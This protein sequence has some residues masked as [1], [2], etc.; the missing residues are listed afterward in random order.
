MKI[1]IPCVL[2]IAL[3]SAG[4]PNTFAPAAAT[5]LHQIAGN[6]CKDI[7]VDFAQ[8]SP[9]NQV[10]EWWGANKFTFDSFTA[11]L[12][13]SNFNFL[14]HLEHPIGVK[15]ITI[16]EMG[17]TLLSAVDPRDDFC[18]YKEDVAN[19]KCYQGCASMPFK[20]KGLS[21]TG[22]C[23]PEY[24]LKMTSKVVPQCADG[25]TNLKYCPDAKKVK[26]QMT[27][28]AGGSCQHTEDIADNKC[29]EGCAGKRFKNKG[30]SQPGK[31]PAKY[32]VVESSKQ[33][34]QCDD[35]VTNV[36]WCPDAR[37][38]KVTMKVKGASTQ[39]L[40]APLADAIKC[41]GSDAKIMVENRFSPSIKF[42]MCS[43]KVDPKTGWAC[44]HGTP[45]TD[46]TRRVNMGESVELDVSDDIQ[47]IMPVTF[48]SEGAVDKVSRCY[49][50]KPAAGWGSMIVDGAWWS[51]LQLSC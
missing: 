11:G 27:T 1:I 21:K 12:C 16:R 10:K 3:A 37:K 18:R 24:S 17:T 44:N 29:Y 31:C 45:Y 28:L 9:L 34:E 15:G 35:G 26:V 20:T 48:T 22:K 51:S 50:S 25:V 30:L 8:E 33:V 32:N 4:R 7:T 36:R 23:P 41:G 2:L 47:T 14:G 19:N 49:F 40:I 46:C 38:V 43:K 5:K 6:H 13:P 42:R 39:Q